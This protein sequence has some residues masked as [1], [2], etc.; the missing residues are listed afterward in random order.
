MEPERC[1]AIRAPKGKPR[2]VRFLR[3]A[4]RGALGGF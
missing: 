3:K 1:L 4:V 2:C